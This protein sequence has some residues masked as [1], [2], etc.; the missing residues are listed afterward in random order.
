MMF[1]RIC[2]NSNSFR[3]TCEM[4]ETNTNTHTH[5]T[6]VFVAIFTQTISMQSFSQ[7][8]TNATNLLK[9]LLSC[10]MHDVVGECNVDDAKCVCVL[11]PVLRPPPTSNRD[12]HTSTGARSNRTKFASS[13]KSWPVC[14]PISFLVYIVA[15]LL[16]MSKL[17]LSLCGRHRRRTYG[18]R[19]IRFSD[20]FH[21]CR[22]WHRFDA[23]SL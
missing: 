9:W 11:H 14:K 10:Y 2:F 3:V 22:C 5:T 12:A 15:F 18:V 4:G 7:Q 21:V 1:G 6:L 16:T 20:N 19:G 23:N 17:H 13:V 8:I